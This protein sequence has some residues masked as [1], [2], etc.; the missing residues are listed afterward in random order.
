M[1]DTELTRI[2]AARVPVTDGARGVMTREWYRFL[3]NLFTI[4]GSGQ[5]NSMP[6]GQDLAP[7][8]TP[9]ANGKRY[10]SFYDTASQNAAATNTAYPITLN[11]TQISHGVWIGSPSSRVY[12]DRV[13][14]YNFQFSLQLNKTSSNAKNVFIWCRINGI[15]VAYSATKVTLAGNS[16]ATVAAWNFVLDMNAG[17]YFELV[18]ST[19]DTSCFIQANTSVS[20]VPS[21]PSV[22]LTVTDNIN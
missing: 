10:G 13:G 3:F 2:P 9:Q 4:S 20:P 7:S 16:S 14:T 5:A 8:Y 12:V 11:A 15:D 17:D 22:I 18:W 21:I 19:D 1:P 6:A